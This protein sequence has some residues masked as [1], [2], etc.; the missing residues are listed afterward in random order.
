MATAPALADEVLAEWSR[1][2]QDRGCWH[3]RIVLPVI[4]AVQLIWLVALCIAAYYV[5]GS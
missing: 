1:G 3:H 2:R 5:L 4:A